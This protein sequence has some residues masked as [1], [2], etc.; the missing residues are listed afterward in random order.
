MKMTSTMLNPCSSGSFCFVTEI[1][2]SEN[3]VGFG[4]SYA[5][6]YFINRWDSAQLETILGDGRAVVAGI[7]HVM[8]LHLARE[9]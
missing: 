5:C 6:C 1:S 2:K 8:Y 9:R 3:A 7:E 4:L